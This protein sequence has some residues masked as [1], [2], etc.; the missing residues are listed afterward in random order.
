MVLSGF[1]GQKHKQKARGF[2]T[3]PG[4]GIYARTVAGKHPVV[5]TGRIW[6][7]VEVPP[8]YLLKFFLKR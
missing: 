8:R 1:A 4:N 3:P 7:V 6:V 2:L 5:Q